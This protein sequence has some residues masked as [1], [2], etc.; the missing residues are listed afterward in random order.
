M[1]TDLED[2][3]TAR[4]AAH[5]I[6]TFRKDRWWLQPAIT[7]S[8]LTAFV[9]YGSWVAF[10]GRDY[11]VEPYLSPFYSPCIAS[12]CDHLTFKL[13]GD[14]WKLSP[15]LLILPFPMTFRLTCYY[16][17]KAYYRSFY[18]SPPACA[19]KEPHHS[20]SGETRFPL[21][22]QNIHRY[23]FYA[24]LPF[25]II[26][27]YDAVLAFNFPDGFGMGVGTLVLTINA[28]LLGIYT[29]SCHSCRHLCGGHVNTFSKA[30]LRY[31]AWKIVTKLNQRHMGLAWVSLVWVALS[32]VYVRLL[33][34]GNLTD[35]RFF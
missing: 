7:A 15:A 1:A 27:G 31:R 21:I 2:K 26:L 22:L 18:L 25:P 10:I 3:P 6:G 33:A 14:W 11:Y 9:V 16:Y 34:T 24:A 23:S 13:V 35:L 30:P 17:R 19:V 5:A 8:V 4:S 29:V 28:I 32:D 12:I 20:Y